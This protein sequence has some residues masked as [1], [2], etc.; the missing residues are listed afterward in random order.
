M[1]GCGARASG[2]T[3]RRRGGLTTIAPLLSPRRSGRGP[4][5]PSRAPDEFARSLRH[6]RCEGTPRQPCA[7]GSLAVLAVHKNLRF[8]SRSLRYTVGLEPQQSKPQSILM[9][10][11]EAIEQAGSSSSQLAV[12]ES[13]MA[14]GSGRVQNSTMPSRSWMGPPILADRA[15][16][17][18]IGGE[19]NG[20]PHG[21]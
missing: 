4:H 7:P 12:N 18:D 3:S 19:P 1:A 17:T 13:D 8:L 6:G 9:S 14:M 5:P 15:R 20:W 2:S 16:L 11:A 21:P 10:V